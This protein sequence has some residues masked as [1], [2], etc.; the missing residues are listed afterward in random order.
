[1]EIRLQHDVTGSKEYLTFLFSEYLFPSKYSL[2]ILCKSKQ[3]P[4]RYNI[5]REWVFFLNTVYNSNIQG[6]TKK[7]S[8]K[9]V[10]HFLSDRW[11]V[12]IG[13]KLVKFPFKIMNDYKEN[14][15][16]FWGY[17]LPHFLRAKAELLLSVRLS[18]RN[19]VCPSVCHTGGSVKNGTS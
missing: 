5:K 3:F 8:L 1:M 2:N 7:V 15:Q 19:S 17:F 10:C 18:H 4:Q 11:Q 14:D 13:D 9:V 6:A 16:K 12:W